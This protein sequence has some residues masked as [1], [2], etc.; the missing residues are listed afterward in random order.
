MGLMQLM[1]QLGLNATSFES[2]LKRSKSAASQFGDELQS[3]VGNKITQV[4]GAVA[5]EETIRR[6]VEYGSKVQDLSNRLGISTDAVQQWDFALQQNGSSIEQASGFFEKLG[7]S[8]EKALKGSE[9]QINAFKRLGVSIEQLKTSRIEDVAGVIARA[10]ESGDPQAL[11]APLREVGGKGAGAMA[12]A[13]RDGL[14]EALGAA[15]IIPQDQIEA[16]DRAADTFQELKN[17]ARAAFAPMI[18]DLMSL[19]LLL[20]EVAENLVALPV[21]AFNAFRESLEKM[22]TSSV[23]GVL[24]GIATAI[25]P[26]TLLG[27][28]KEGFDAMREKHAEEAAAREKKRQRELEKKPIDL[29]DEKEAKE[30]Q[31]EAAAAE[32]KA[33]AEFDKFEK[34]FDSDWKKATA[35]VKQKPDKRGKFF[36]PE[37]NSLQDI[38]NMLG[39]VPDRTVPD[40]LDVLH[41]DL[42]TLITQSKDTPAGLTFP[43]S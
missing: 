16:L 11:I 13:F 27:G 41:N 21:G 24:K 22:D 32:K 40:K 14:A 26:T 39:G 29:E 20:K 17:Q 12:A 9:A 7:I 15:P 25:V 34:E 8:R 33:Q 23:G 2:G 19:L 36:R 35:E 1:V 38:G 37:G 5:I 42:R 3:S 6:T 18:A 10:F 4:F 31:K 28:A 43:S 30:K